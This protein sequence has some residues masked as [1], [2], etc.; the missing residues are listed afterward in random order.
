M[1]WKKIIIP[2]AVVL[3]LVL[4]VLGVY[5]FVPEAFDALEKIPDINVEVG[6]ANINI[7]DI[8]LGE[9]ELENGVPKFGV[10]V[11][12]VVCIVCIILFFALSMM[13]NVVAIILSI[14]SLVFPFLFGANIIDTYKEAIEMGISSAEA[15]GAVAIQIFLLGLVTFIAP[16]VLIGR[17]LVRLL[18]GDVTR[19]ASDLHTAQRILS[20][21]RDDLEA[22]NRYVEAFNNGMDPEDLHYNSSYC[23][24]EH[25]PYTKNRPYDQEEPKQI[26]EVERDLK[27]AEEEYEY[28][29]YVVDVFKNR[30]KKE[31]KEEER[32]LIKE[33]KQEKAKR[34]IAAFVIAIICVLVNSGLLVL[35][36]YLMLLWAWPIALTIALNIVYILYNSVVGIVDGALAQIL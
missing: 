11:W 8:N 23:Y 30:S 34:T 31:N 26:F 17:Y 35:G 27:T 1:D 19:G 2:I 18:L 25:K 29:E 14:V 32:K 5:F 20:D 13:H 3:V 36:G 24:Y 10:T 16:A 12:T 15:S 33:E 9:L 7:G 22:I 21:K 4:V 6:N 28:W